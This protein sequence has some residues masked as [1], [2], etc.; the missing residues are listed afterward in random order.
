MRTHMRLVTMQGLFCGLW[1]DGY[2]ADFNERGEKHDELRDDQE[3]EL[4]E[5]PPVLGAPPEQPP[6]A[7]G[8]RVQLRRSTT[9]LSSHVI[10]LL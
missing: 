10:A 7:P 8:G 1:R 5:E 2:R 4:C 6:A 3:P 9:A